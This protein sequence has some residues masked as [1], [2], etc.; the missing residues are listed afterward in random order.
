MNFRGHIGLCAELCCQEAR[1]IASR[2]WGSE[3]EVG[4]LKVEFRI[5]HNV[6]RL[7]ITMTAII[8]MHVV[9]CRHKLG[10]VISGDF[11]RES[12]RI[13]DKIKEITSVHKFENDVINFFWRLLL[14]SH[15]SFAG[16]NKI[17]NV[18][19]LDCFERLNLS[20]NK[21]KEFRVIV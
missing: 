18:R 21:L 9:Q 3:A 19:V 12:T 13:G 6:L 4:N 15:D 20:L 2:H 5:E 11:L 7:E 17:N 10:E 16:L 1:T 8:L 14:V